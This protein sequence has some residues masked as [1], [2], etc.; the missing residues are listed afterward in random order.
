MEE[1]HAWRVE[2]T[3]GAVLADVVVSAG[4]G[5]SEPSAPAIPGLETFAGP[6]VHTARWPADLDLRG[7]RV[8]IVGTGASAIQVVPAIAGEVEGL[9]V[10]QRTPAWILP[11]RD[12]AISA[13]ERALFR[14]RRRPSA[15]PDAPSGRCASCAASR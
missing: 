2:T 11:R 12:R 14:G 15:R 10:F 7:R 4:G 1:E 13:R 8:A 6:V 5:L 3:L 9:V